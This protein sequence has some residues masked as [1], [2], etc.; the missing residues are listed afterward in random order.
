ME[1]GRRT[2]DQLVGGNSPSIGRIDLA[3][4]WLLLK[5]GDGAYLVPGTLF[6]I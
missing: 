1:K 2:G 6:F 4:Q 3:S 5:E